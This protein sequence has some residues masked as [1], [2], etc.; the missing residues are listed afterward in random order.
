MAAASIY[1]NYRVSRMRWL[2]RVPQHCEEQRAKT[3]FRE[4]DERSETGQVDL[5]G[6]QPG[7]DDVVSDDVLAALGDDE[8]GSTDEENPDGDE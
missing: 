4:V 1:P 3:Y 6:W 7:P 8:A 2:P 5:R